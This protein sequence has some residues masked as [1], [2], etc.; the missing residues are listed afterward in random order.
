VSPAREVEVAGAA[1]ERRAFLRLAGVAVGLGLLP[2]GCS[3]VPEVLTPRSALGVLTPRTYAVFTAAAMRL[4]GPPGAALIADRRVDVGLLADDWLS[5]TPAVAGP[6][7]QALLLLEFGVWPL[8]GKV[9][10]FT[11]LDGGAQDAVL[12]ECMTSS[13]DTKR[14]LFRGVRSLAML[15]FYGAPATRGLIRF[16]GPF[17]SD[18]VTIADAMRE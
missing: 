4:V 12:G 8:F 15:T 10:P 3:G 5:R 16:P 18:S 17:G 9:R 14:A 7:G 1:L 2:S 11:A 6:L 13:L